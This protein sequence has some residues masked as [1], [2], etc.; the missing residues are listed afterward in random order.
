MWGIIK[1]II[2][3]SSHDVQLNPYLF[4][5]SKAYVKRYVELRNVS[6]SKVNSISPWTF[7]SNSKQKDHSVCIIS[8]LTLYR[9][10]RKIHK[11]NLSSGLNWNNESLDAYE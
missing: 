5:F 9:I 7:A 2:L 4:E 11:V 8:D 1:M 6:L 3:S 10:Q